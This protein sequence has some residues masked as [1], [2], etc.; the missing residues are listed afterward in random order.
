MMHESPELKQKHKGKII[1][2]VGLPASG[3]STEA[4]FRLHDGNVMRVNR[5]DIRSMLF[6]RWKGRKE[7]VVTSIETAAIKSAVLEGYDIIIDDTNLN[8]S[9][10][11]KW[12]NLAN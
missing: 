4:K 11:Q 8:P 7:Q 3:K 5:D 1:M 6:A 10:Q 12:K 2:F 9:T